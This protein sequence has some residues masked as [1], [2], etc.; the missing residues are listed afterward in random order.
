MEGKSTTSTGKSDFPAIASACASR[1]AD[2]LSA[3]PHDFRGR[4]FEELAA[5]RMDVLVPVRFPVEN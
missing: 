1:E 2:I 3:G 4:F 5:V